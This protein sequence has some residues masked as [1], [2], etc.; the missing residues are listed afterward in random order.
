MDQR[1]AYLDVYNCGSI[2][3]FLGA[4]LTNGVKNKALNVSLFAHMFLTIVGKR[5]KENGRKGNQLNLN[6]KYTV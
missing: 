3:F 2:F 6:A 5:A 4:T 1:R